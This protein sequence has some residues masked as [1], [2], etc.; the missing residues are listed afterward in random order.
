MNIN[1]PRSVFCFT[2]VLSRSFA[3]DYFNAVC[4]L[5]AGDF[6]VAGLFGSVIKTFPVVLTEN[7]LALSARIDMQLNYVVT[8]LGRIITLR[9][10]GDII[11]PIF[12]NIAPPLSFGGNVIF[13]PVYR[14]L[15]PRPSSSRAICPPADRPLSVNAESKILPPN[16]YC[17]ESSAHCGS[18]WNSN[19]IGLIMA[20]P[21]SCNIRVQMNICT[22]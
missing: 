6:C 7:V 11:A 22:E 4:V 8:V 14:G 18:F 16:I 10:L 20:T 15:K 5:C 2:I 19:A 17:L 12:I 13:E 3:Y 21:V 1:L 9:P